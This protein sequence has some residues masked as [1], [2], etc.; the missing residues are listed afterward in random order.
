M[1]FAVFKH[2]QFVIVYCSITYNNVVNV[3]LI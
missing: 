1:G 2:L 3:V